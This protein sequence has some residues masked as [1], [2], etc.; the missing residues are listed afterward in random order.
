VTYVERAKQ[1]DQLLARLADIAQELE[2]APPF[3]AVDLLAEQKRLL[4]ELRAQGIGP[5]D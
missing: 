1:P 5:I 3:V 4:A 2:Q